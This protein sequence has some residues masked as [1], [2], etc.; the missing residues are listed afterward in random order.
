MKV[1]DLSTF[2]D[3]GTKYLVCP[4]HSHF[5]QLSKQL[6]GILYVPTGLFS[7]ALCHNLNAL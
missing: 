6:G 1:G 2:K 3:G 5:A 4:A 7:S